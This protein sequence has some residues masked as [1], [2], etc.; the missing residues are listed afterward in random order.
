ML[1][2]LRRRRLRT[3]ITLFGIGM[4][5]GA[6]VALV[7]SSRSLEQQWLQIYSG[8]GTDLTV[9]QG[10]FLNTS[11]DQS[12]AAKLQALP[13]VAEVAPVMFNIMDL[14]SDVNAL[15]YGWQSN[16]YEFDSLKILSGRTFRD[17]QPE[18]MLGDLLADHLKMKPG[19][20]MRI[21]GATFTVT[22][23]YHGQSALQADAFILPLDQLQSLSSLQGKVSTVD[24]RLR[25]TPKGESAEQYLKRAQSEIDAAIPGLSAVPAAERAGNNQFVRVAKA[26]A[27]ATSCLAIMIGI[28]GAANTMVMSVFE[29]TKEIG[30]LRALGWKQWQILALI[31]FEASALGLGGG[32]LGIAVGWVALHILAILPQ[33]SGFVSASI[34]WNLLAEAI[35]I[36]VLSGLVAGMV[37]AWHAGK[38]SPVDALHYE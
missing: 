11:M 28:L 19:D 32:L 17:G 13:V 36:A 26:S 14:T 10:T 22:A 20:T 31:L 16:S 30:I 35:G 18:V 34:S 8:S 38:L 27:W 7:G 1:K 33:T 15:A 23:I 3:L 9:V 6:F 29:R 21:Q 2:N 37:P 24:I 25:P 12:A 4:A 5:V